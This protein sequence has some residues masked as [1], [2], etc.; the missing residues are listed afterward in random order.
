MREVRRL[1]AEIFQ[2]LG[3]PTRLAILESLQGGEL[4]VGEILSRL[5][6]AQSN[7]S[8]HL[9][10]LRG[11]RLVVTRRDGNRVYYSLRDPI[12]GQVMALMR[13]YTVSH[14]SEDMT[15]LREMGLGRRVAAR[16]ARRGARRARAWHRV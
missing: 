12:L 2:A 13:R 15:L 9:T 3:H 14:L 7:V 5:E 11:R 4:T 10:I 16:S 6:M 8:Q 1:K